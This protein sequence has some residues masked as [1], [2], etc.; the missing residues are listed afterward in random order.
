MNEEARKNIAKNRF[1]MD[2][3][4]NEFT[5]L[6]KITAH[7]DVKES[8]LQGI[9]IMMRKFGAG[10]CKIISYRLTKRRK[11]IEKGKTEA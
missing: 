5:K 1:G 11:G 2:E 10:I 6:S 7:L 4:V 3:F 8:K 9:D